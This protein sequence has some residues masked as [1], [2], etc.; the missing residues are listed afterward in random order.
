MDVLIAKRLDSSKSNEFYDAGFYKQLGTIGRQYIDAGLAALNYVICDYDLIS[1]KTQMYAPIDNP[2]TYAKGDRNAAINFIHPELYTEMQT[3][4]T[5][6]A[7]ILFGGEQARSVEAKN[8]E[9]DNAAEAINALLAWNDAKIGIYL[10]GWLWIWAAVVYNRGVFYEKCCQDVDVDWEEVE[11]ADVS[12]EKVQ[13]TDA[14]GSP[15]FNRKG[16]PVMVY[17]TRTRQRKKR[18]YSGFFNDVDLVSPYDFICDPTPPVSQLQEKAR[19][20]G[21]RVRIPWNELKRRSELDPNDDMY[22]LPEVVKKLKIQKG[23]VV[24]PGAIGGTQSGSQNFSRTYYDRQLRAANAAGIG[25][26]GSGLIPGSD[27]VNKEDGGTVECF[28]LTIRI[29]PADIGMYKD[30]VELEMIQ[31]LITN[32]ADVLSCNILPNKH[33]QFPYAIAEARPDAHRQFSPSL[34]M[35]IVPVQNRID[36]LNTVHANAQAR[37][38][39]ILIVDDT[40][41]DVANLLTPDK[42]GLMIMRK[43]PGKGA[44][45]ADLVSQIPLKDVTANYNA[46][47]QMWIDTA[48][49]TTGAHAFTQGQ[50]ED[51]SQTLG[52]FDSV[53][54]MAVGRISSIARLIS[55]QGITPQTRRFVM[56]AQ[57]FMESEMMIRVVGKGSEFDPDNPPEKWKLIKKADI[58]AGVDVVPHDGSLPGADNRTVSA[59][60]RAIEAYSTSPALAPAFDVTQ[61]GALD[62]T[63]I[64]REMLKKGGLAV[65]RFSVTRQQA[66][67]NQRSRLAAQGIPQPGLGQ[68]PPEDPGAAGM[69]AATTPPLPQAPAGAAQVPP[70]PQ[71]V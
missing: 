49:D 62:P 30:D 53:K 26:I 33:D 2:T 16:E 7:Q 47:M 71:P 11:E 60:S 6:L 35:A 43:E 57:Q 52:Q 46:E 44:P 8:E 61:P 25:G 70:S 41:C 21:H 1:D 31:L 29:K 32:Q 42:N 69:A 3:L 37:M 63:R 5:F 48:R 12:K 19:F 66:I 59:C 40:K 22:V 45:I 24:T 13:A 64:L 4:T 9:D 14:N 27:S 50:T 65:E 15:R 36:N 67:D 10:K 34:A 38:G 58:Q 23:N 55:E 68:P 51:P 54:Q 18:I 39:N 28:N 56:N 17:P 20:M